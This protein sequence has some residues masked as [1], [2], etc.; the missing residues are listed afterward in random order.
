MAVIWTWT[1]PAGRGSEKA[2]DVAHATG[3]GRRHCDVDRRRSLVSRSPVTE[4]SPGR[5][6]TVS[7]DSGAT[8]SASSIEPTARLKGVI[9]AV[10]GSPS[11]ADQPA[12]D[13][14]P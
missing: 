10:A 5:C 14:A 12:A 9:Q 4:R 13:V 3:V 2:R 7:S 8:A 11:V 6:V 1:G